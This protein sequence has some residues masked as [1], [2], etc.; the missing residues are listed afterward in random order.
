MRNY[1]CDYCIFRFIVK[2][3]HYV[4]IWEYAGTASELDFPA[5]MGN[6]QGW[7]VKIAVGPNPFY[8]LKSVAQ[9]N[10]TNSLR[11]LTMALEQ[12][13]NMKINN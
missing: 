5:Y 4:V 2:K 7:D 9:P 13:E 11:Y 6:K 1:Q 8:S 3:D 12:V 10:R